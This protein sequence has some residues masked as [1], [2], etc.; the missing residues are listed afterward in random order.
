MHPGF[1][2]LHL[3]KSVNNSLSENANTI[4]YHIPSSNFQSHLTIVKYFQ[5]T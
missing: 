4:R 1:I 2:E 5:L 3:S